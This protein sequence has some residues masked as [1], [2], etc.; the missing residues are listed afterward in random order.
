MIVV[1]ERNDPLSLLELHA[2][3]LSKMVLNVHPEVA[4]A[5]SFGLY[6]GVFVIA[7]SDVALK[8]LHSED[9][10]YEQE[11]KDNEQHI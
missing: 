5:I 1:V 8:E 6:S 7:S 3:L 11:E 2:N 10:E 4:G 9:A